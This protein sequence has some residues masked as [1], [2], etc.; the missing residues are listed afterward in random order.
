MGTI[1]YHTMIANLETHFMSHMTMHAL[2]YAT[3]E[4]YE[5]R[6]GLFVQADAAYAAINKEATT[7]SVGHNFMS[8][9]T[10]AEKK[11]M[12]GKF[13]VSHGVTDFE[14][15]IESGNGSVDWRALGGVNDVQ[16]QG[17]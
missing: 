7:Y 16:N 10:E 9:M 6:F 17:R 5:F 14:E 13:S 1:K 3:K 4:E 12:H 11:Q 8:T 2:S 15:I